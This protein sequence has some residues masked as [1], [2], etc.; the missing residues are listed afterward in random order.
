M[1][2]KTYEEQLAYVERKFWEIKESARK[3][4]PYEE[5]KF[6]LRDI[7]I[8]ELLSLLI[9]LE[10]KI[11]ATDSDGNVKLNKNGRPKVN[12]LKVVSQLGFIIGRVVGLIIESKK[13]K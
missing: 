10:D 7:I 6:S 5:S 3:P 11:M 8:Q 1:N 12:W 2:N 9:G 13:V 4:S